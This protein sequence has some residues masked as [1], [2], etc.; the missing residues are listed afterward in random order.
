MMPS[1]LNV[2]AASPLQ[3]S[4]DVISNFSPRPM[5][6]SAAIARG[7]PGNGMPSNDVA[8]FHTCW[9]KDGSFWFAPV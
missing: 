1:F 3:N 8:R 2:N 6:R 4:G 9:M 7:T 5:N